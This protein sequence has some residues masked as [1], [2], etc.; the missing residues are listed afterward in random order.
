MKALYRQ[1]LLSLV[2]GDCVYLAQPA[3]KGIRGDGGQHGAAAD[4]MPT[5][6]VFTTLNLHAV[7]T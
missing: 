6:E 7:Q 3:P 1:A 5:V 4:N 2:A